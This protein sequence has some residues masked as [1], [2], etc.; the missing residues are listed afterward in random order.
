[1]KALGITAMI[2]A[3]VA[4]FVPVFGPYLTLLGALLAALAGGPGLTFG[5]VAILVNILNIAVLSPSLWLTAGMAEAEKPGEG[6]MVLAGMGI[7]LIG[8][9]IA[10]TMVLGVVHA[11]WRKSNTH[12]KPQYVPAVDADYQKP[13][14]THPKPQL[15][16]PKNMR[17][18]AHVAVSLNMT[19]AMVIRAIQ[20]GAIQGTEIDGRWYV[21]AK[22]D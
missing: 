2:F 21:V 12:A 1:M 6:A 4:I 14:K 8:A 7:L 20:A 13:L 9:Q 19:E 18:A 17:P 15:T 22:D 10:A 11:I 16:P 3:I 5:V